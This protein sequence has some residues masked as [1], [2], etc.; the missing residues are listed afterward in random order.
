MKSI[1]SFAAAA[2]L[3]SATSCVDDLD[4]TNIDPNVNTNPVAAQV[5]N[6]CY[7]ALALA[8]NSGPDGD[9]DIDG[10]DGGTT[11]FVRQLINSQVITTD[12]GICCWGD[13]GIPAYNYNQW[14]AD[15]PMLKGLYY[16]LYFGVTI[17]NQYLANFTSDATMDAEIRFLR[18]LNYYY[19]LDGW[20]NVPFKESVST[21][22]AP[23]YTR[24]QIFDFVESELLD[25]EKGMSEP[26]AK[27]SSDEG[28]GRADKAA[29]WLLLA[30]LYLNAEAYVGE[31]RYADAETYAKKVMDSDYALAANPINEFSAYETLFMGDNGET[32]AAHEII[33]PLL[34]DG[35]TTAAYCTSEFAIAATWKDD[36]YK[37]AGKKGSGCSEAWSGN[38][39][40]QDL[41][42]KFVDASKA[43]MDTDAQ[44]MVALAGDDRALFWSKD[45]KLDIAANDDFTK[46][47]STTK[48]SNFYATGGAPHDAKFADMDWPL[49]R[50]AEA[51]LIYAE[52]TARLNGGLASADGLAAVNTLRSRAHATQLAS[53]NL[54]VLCDEW[55][56][57]FYFEGYR[58]TTL[59]RFNRYGGNTGYTWQWKGGSHDG[60]NFS[61]NYNLF[62]IP[63][64]D[65]NANANLVQ[66]PGF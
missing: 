43:E 31:N 5:F 32:D 35:A 45:R 7:A 55:S 15:H 8:G 12:E 41:I 36:M 47:Y 46:G 6:K 48:F 29:A 3:L 4:V 22:A 20:G 16:R 9:C 65:L 25:C 50:K 61:V 30:R 23:Q 66:N 40:R 28:Y 21:D 14:G 57:E 10:L 33:L 44:A 2:V 11:G 1:Y 37:A 49:M 64:T 27:N 26:K 53:A 63:D 51:Y 34:Q 38:R 13:P 19:L 56:R 18:A 17:C 39:C 42:E 60:Q 62:P 52:A 54:D 58:R 24:K 59:I